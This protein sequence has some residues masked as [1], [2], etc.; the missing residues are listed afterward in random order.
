MEI[1]PHSR[2]ISLWRLVHGRYEKFIQ[3]TVGE[4]RR[5]GKSK[6]AW[7]DNIKIGLQE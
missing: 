2:H 6:L 1:F 3:L 7:E 5:L 4:K